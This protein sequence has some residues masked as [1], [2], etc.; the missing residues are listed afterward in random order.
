[1]IRKSNVTIKDIANKLGL[2]TS[3]V[4]RALSGNKDVHP[5]TREAVKELAAQLDYQPNVL[6]QNLKMQQTHIIGVIIPESANPFYARVLSGLLNVA[7]QHGYNVI[8]LQSMES[9]A[10]EKN[11]VDVL[12]NARV[13][14]VI[15][16]LSVATMNLD[17]FEKLKA[18]GY[19]LVFFD[20]VP[21]D[22]DVSRIVSDN[23]DSAFRATE[24]LIDLGCKRVA[25]VNGPLHLNHCR[26]RL[27]GYK[28]ALEKHGIPVREDYIVHT[29]YHA[30]DVELYTK[31][32]MNMPEPPDGIFAINDKAAIEIIKTLKIMKYR[33]PEDVAVI[34]FNN[35]FYGEFVDPP[36]SS[37]EIPAY[38]M[39]RASMQLLLDQIHEDEP[40]H[41]Q[42]TIPSRLVIRESS[43]RGVVS[44]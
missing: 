15:A 36:L 26:W 23:Y 29:R 30:Y 40:I 19:P 5:K 12:I 38:E 35:E 18:R 8:T 1:M 27:R 41:R 32:L 31:K 20:R 33:V 14:G 3:T 17:H 2:S 21:D 11:N 7:T 34:G 37:I 6:A 4:S 10:A 13:D 44:I 22:P 43:Q 39:G 24:H 9:E 25:R 42:V 16:S 28:D